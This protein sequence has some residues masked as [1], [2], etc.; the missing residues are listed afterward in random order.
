MSSRHSKAPV[1]PFGEPYHCAMAEVTIVGDDPP[2][3]GMHVSVRVRRDFT[4]I[5]ADRFL[6]LARQAYRGLHPDAEADEAHAMVTS[7]A[8]AMFAILEH[9]G[10]VGDVVEAKL[11]SSEASGLMLG[12]WRAQV[13]ANESDPLLPGRD[14]LRTDDVFAVPSSAGEP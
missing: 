2:A 9:A 8:D 4:I 12:G 7:V 5:D 14:C 13:T 6:E 10:V 1:V 3:D 11:R